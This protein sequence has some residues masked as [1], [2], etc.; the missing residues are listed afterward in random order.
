MKYLLILILT[1]SL[2]SLVSADTTFYD[3]PDDMF[4]YSNPAVTP[5]IIPPSTGGH[6]GAGI[7][8]TVNLTL[9]QKLALEGKNE[10]EIEVIQNQ[11]EL[12][13]QQSYLMTVLLILTMF[14]I[15]FILIFIMYKK[16]LFKS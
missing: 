6:G 15:V 10:T 12:K 8:G 1:I 3:N 11:I 5:P 4:I 2:I 16:K 7:I 9:A 13:K 14:I